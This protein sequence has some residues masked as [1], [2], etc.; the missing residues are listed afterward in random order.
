MGFVEKVKLTIDRH[1][2]FVGENKL[3]AAVSGGADSMAMLHVLLQ[4]K[5]E[6]GF[7]LHVAHINHGIRGSEADRDEAFLLDFCKTNSLPLAVLKSDIPSLTEDTHEG[8]EECGRR[9]RYSFLH[10]L[11]E[12]A[13]IATAH[14]LNDSIETLIFN[15]TRG[16]GLKGLCGIAPKTGRVIRPLIDCT[17]S[18]IE[19]YC[20]KNAIGFVED[21]T[22]FEDA[23][24]RNFIRNNIVFKFSAI[25]KE[26]EKAFFRLFE[27]LKSDEELLDSL[28][29]ETLE[30]AYLDGK[31]AYR[32]D[33]IRDAHKS[34]RNRAL[35]KI[36][37]KYTGTAPE[38]KHVEILSDLL[39]T[40]GRHN[41]KNNVFIKVDQ[42]VL[43][44]MGE[45]R[46]TEEWCLPF[47]AR[48]VTKNNKT[49]EFFIVNKKEYKSLVKI[50]KVT[51]E[52][53]LDY[54]NIKGNVFIRSRKGGDK[55][56][57][58]KRACSKSLKKLF[59]EDRIPPTRRNRIAVLADDEGLIWLEGY[60]ADSRCAVTLNTEK[61]MIVKVGSPN[62]AK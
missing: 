33:I 49:Y 31:D 52:N 27:S 16:S 37:E 42:G 22:N 48:K 21:L 50:H 7:D 41:F 14:S 28:T 13:I 10:S 57:L 53:C 9:I 60:G 61:I 17:R 15:M 3:F 4:I 62:D 20:K 56:T 38:S 54:D 51:L 19:A 18:E 5:D 11:D 34:I 58:A 2:M 12:K 45:E 1:D 59:N 43:K 6:Y 24:T 36:L 55:I 30:R 47:R 26:F 44:T 35:I 29:E 39:E 23:Y 46:P 32:T 8:E 40:E 25:N